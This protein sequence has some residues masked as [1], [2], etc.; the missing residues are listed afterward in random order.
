M[1][2]PDFSRHPRTGALLPVDVPP[3]IIGTTLIQ[4]VLSEL[5][6]RGWKKIL[7]VDD[8]RTH[9]AFGRQLRSM[10]THLSLAD[11]VQADE[12]T[13]QR[14][15][16]EG[17]GHDV[18]LAVGSGTIN[19]ICKHAAFLLNI[20]YI[21][22]ATALSMNGYL[23]INASINVGGVKTTL[24]GKLPAAAFFDM[25]VLSTAPVYLAQAGFGDALCRSTAQADW[26]LSHQLLDTPYSD[27]PFE[28]LAPYENLLWGNARGIA[29]NNPRSL[30]ILAYTLI[31]S[32]LGMTI[33]GGSYPASQ[34][35]HLLAHT[36]EMLKGSHHSHSHGAC[37]AVTTSIMAE[38]QEE[39]L[40]LGNKI[41]FPSFPENLLMK[42]FKPEQVA[43]FQTEYRKK[44]LTAER[45][46][47]INTR[48]RNNGW[49][50]A[51][52]IAGVRKPTEKIR[53]RL[54]AAGCPTTPEA[55]G[56]TNED[57]ILAKKIA[58]FTRERFT[59]LDLL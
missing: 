20:P 55:I 27:L 43:Y 52:S 35:E 2:I 3:I 44:D 4:N 51:A 9:L 26:L 38:I 40:Y 31:L 39:G 49:E 25:E 21:L 19:D 8:A 14:I 58:P 37:I 41:S 48:L 32:G 7:L 54:T 57:I 46:A 16:H 28:L 23:S 53:E 47:D 33:T 30:S 50:I 12:N 17:I 42:H 24:P 29:S 22:C 45:L 11:P 6:Q 13:V 1:Q 36:L 34:G 18:I 10:A 15:V 56:W 59:F 5:S